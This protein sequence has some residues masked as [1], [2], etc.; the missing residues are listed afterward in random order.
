MSSIKQITDDIDYYLG[1]DYAKEH[2]ELI[3]AVIHQEAIEYLAKVHSE[4]LR[5]LADEIRGL[6]LSG[7]DDIALELSEYLKRTAP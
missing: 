2:P 5:A 7:L 3:A 4:S 1:Q 6:N